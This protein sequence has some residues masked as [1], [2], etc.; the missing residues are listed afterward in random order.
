MLFMLFMVE[1]HLFRNRQYALWQ[2]ARGPWKWLLQLR[3]RLLGFLLRALVRDV[4]GFIEAH[5]ITRSKILLRVAGRREI[6]ARGY[7]PD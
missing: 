7:W 6:A 1:N 3:A 5:G 2:R 4:F